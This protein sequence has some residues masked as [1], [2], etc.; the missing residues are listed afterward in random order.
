MF[1]NFLMR[2]VSQAPPLLSLLVVTILLVGMDD[3]CFFQ[4]YI[5][6]IHICR[7]GSGVVNVYDGSCLCTT[8]RP[9]PLKSLMHLTT[10]ADQTQ[11]NP[12]SEI[13]AISS[14]RK[15]SA[16]RLVGET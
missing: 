4:I 2:V 1:I 9:T 12:T 10:E 5:L 16:L 14:K 6:Q 8:Q 3:N 11:F 15:K 13:L 7:C